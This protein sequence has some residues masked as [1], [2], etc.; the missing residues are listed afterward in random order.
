VLLPSIGALVLSFYVVFFLLLTFS[1]Q[2]EQGMGNDLNK[3]RRVKEVTE[4]CI[5]SNNDLLCGTSDKLSEE[6]D[7]E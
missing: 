2:I 3:N 6:E 1:P 5:E 4:M 7:K